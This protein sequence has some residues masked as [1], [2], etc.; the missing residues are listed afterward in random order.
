LCH[1]YL[2]LV[3]YVVGQCF[4]LVYEFRD[5]PVWSQPFT[6]SGFIVL[7][8]E[9]LNAPLT[10][11]DTAILTDMEWREV[12]FWEITTLGGVLFNSWD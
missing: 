4:R 12:R 3:A 2:P 10:D 11:V 7:S 6:D 8:A 5:P 9:Q 1:A